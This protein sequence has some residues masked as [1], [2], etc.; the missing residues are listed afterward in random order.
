LVGVVQCRDPSQPFDAVFGGDVGGEPS[1]SLETGGGG[2]VDDGPAAG[3]QYGADFVSHGQK[4][5][6]QVHGV[7]GVERVNGH[8]GQQRGPVAAAG[9]V[10]VGDVEPPELHP[11]SSLQSHA[12]RRAVSMG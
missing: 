8:I 7:G 2:H 3:F 1:D 5:A 12:A 4:D 10:V 6:S 9:G 11:A